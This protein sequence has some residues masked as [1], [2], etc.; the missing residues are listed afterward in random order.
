VIHESRHACLHVRSSV[1]L[2]GGRGV[3]AARWVMHTSPE[4]NHHCPATWYLWSSTLEQLV[5]T[6]DYFIFADA[7]NVTRPCWVS[8]YSMFEFANCK[9]YF[10]LQHN[11]GWSILFMADQKPCHLDLGWIWSSNISSYPPSFV[12]L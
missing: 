5:L 8:K 1:C 12:H 11:S 4:T 9:Q 3:E 10:L 2:E 6:I 7:F